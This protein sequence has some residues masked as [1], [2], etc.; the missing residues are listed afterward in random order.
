MTCNIE[1]RALTTMKELAEIQKIESTVWKMDPIPV[2]QTLTALNNGGILLGAYDEGKMIGFLYSFPGFEAGSVHLCSH[3]LGI[4]PAYRTAGLGEKMKLKQ[5]EIARELQYPLIT[6]TFDPL[7]SR[8]AYLN[9]H[10]L[11]ATG[12]L[13]HAD[14]YGSMSDGLNQ[15]LPTDRIL[16]HWN[17][18]E[19]RQRQTHE[20]NE[21]KLLLDADEHGL[22][23]VR[24]VFEQENVTNDVYFVAVPT[25]F[26][27]MKQF[28]FD[29]AV[30]WRMESRTIFCAL[31][32][33]GFLA[34][35]LLRDEERP[36]SY[37][38]FTK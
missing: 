38:V 19:K 21:G 22:P 31:F 11:G 35:D 6:W 30:R 10:K 3:M 5:A 9:L 7:E 24:K 25:D 34:T 26:Q 23:V 32:D 27:E 29:L 20:L 12:A 18:N 28:N 16:I 14:H 33:A 36:V 4:L 15:G 1:I 37:Y 17:I 2:H 13:Y 8:N